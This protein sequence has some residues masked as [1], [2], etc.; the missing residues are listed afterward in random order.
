MTRVQEMDKCLV[1][2]YDLVLYSPL[3]ETAIAVPSHAPSQEASLQSTEVTL[4]QLQH[5][6]ISAKILF[7]EISLSTMN[8]PRPLTTPKVGATATDG[9]GVQTPRCRMMV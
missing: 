8:E 2:L 7:N 1:K 9:R 5:V 3:R 4:G 6:L